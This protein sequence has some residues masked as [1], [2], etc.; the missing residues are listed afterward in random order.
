VVLYLVDDAAAFLF[1]SALGGAGGRGHPKGSPS[2]ETR[3]RIAPPDA[4]SLVREPVRTGGNS[5]GH[6]ERRS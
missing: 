1:I 5:N 3:K 4:P 2:A 6:S